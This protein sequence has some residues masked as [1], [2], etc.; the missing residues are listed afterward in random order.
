MYWG[1]G[2]GGGDPPPKK[3]NVYS[4]SDKPKRKWVTFTYIGKET[5]FVTKLFRQTYF[6]IAYRMND[7]MERTLNLKIKILINT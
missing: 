6:K 4:N 2:G 1:V 7:S 3:Q 5:T